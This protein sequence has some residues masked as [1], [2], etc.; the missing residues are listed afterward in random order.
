MGH[1]PAMARPSRTRPTDP[2]AP[3][4]PSS[5]HA[6]ADPAPDGTTRKA[7]RAQRAIDATA[8]ASTGDSAGTAA[9]TAD[10]TTTSLARL[11]DVA[12]P[13]VDSVV[14]SV[15]G[16]VGQVGHA[17]NAA[18]GGI[19]ELPGMR[20]RRVRRR[21]RIP[22]PSLPDLYPELAK[23]RRIDVGTRTIDVAD[24]AGT[25]VGGGDQRGGDFLPLR[26]FRGQN[27]AGRWQRLLRAQDRL[28]S[29]PP[30]DLVKYADKYWVVDGHNRVA[31]ALYTGQRDVDA[32]VVELVAPGG[33]RTEPLGSLAAEVEA[34]RPIRA[35]AAAD[36]T[37]R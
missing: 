11:A 19:R 16:R 6:P 30:I 5:P 10:T 25:A 12:E 33:H 20:I 4:A 24:I 2:P 7:R 3:E 26:P 27:W 18:V 22:L 37:P 32:S 28:A 13:I 35:R 29:L 21:G 23:A 9:E 17:M 31:L 8:A 1:T 34:A 15:V 14:G 36:E